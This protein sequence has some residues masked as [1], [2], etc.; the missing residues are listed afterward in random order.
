[1]SLQDIED[2]LERVPGSFVPLF[3]MST[4][5]KSPFYVFYYYQFSYFSWI[6]TA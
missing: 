4:L 1:M 3:N 5:N 6:L 2:G